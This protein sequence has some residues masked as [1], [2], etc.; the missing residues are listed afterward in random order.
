MAAVKKVKTFDEKLTEVNKTMRDFED[1]QSK[2]QELADKIKAK[3]DEIVSLK[4]DALTTELKLN[5]IDP[6]DLQFIVKACVFYKDY[7][8]ENE[9]SLVDAN[10]DVA[11]KHG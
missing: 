5:Q 6:N 1:L 3:Q 9:P 7:L 4:F 11:A 2:A 8:A 10:K